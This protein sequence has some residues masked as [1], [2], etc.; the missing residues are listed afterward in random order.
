M[1]IVQI[2]DS[3]VAHCIQLNYREG[4]LIL[5]GIK[6]FLHI[7][8]QGQQLLVMH[9]LHFIYLFFTS[10]LLICFYDLRIRPIVKQIFFPHALIIV[11]FQLLSYAFVG[12]FYNKEV[13]NDEGNTQQ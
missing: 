11:D 6:S 3:P 10:V 13:K 7:V 8:F 12:F 1:L 2:I 5:L 4:C 9:D